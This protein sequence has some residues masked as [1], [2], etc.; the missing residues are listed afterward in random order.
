[1]TGKNALDPV[2]SLAGEFAAFMRVLAD[3][4]ADLIKGYFGRNIG[5]HL[6]SDESPV[7][8]ADRR[9]EE[10]MRAMI[11][12]HYPEH[13]IIGEEFDGY[14]IW[15]RSVFWRPPA[16]PAWAFWQYTDDAKVPGIETP[17]DMN[18][19]PGEPQ[20]LAAFAR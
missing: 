16:E 14:P 8:E 20:E 4:S 11:R 19:F 17:V 13:G 7:T 2:T 1:M 6:K 12:E 9:A 18:V 10:L 3:G 15:I 5:V